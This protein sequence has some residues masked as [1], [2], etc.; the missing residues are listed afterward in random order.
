MTAHDETRSRQICQ[1]TGMQDY[2]CK[3]IKQTTL[4]SLLEKWLN[5]NSP[6]P[7]ANTGL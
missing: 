5:H 6:P 4:K 3:P 2:I 1:D 7:S